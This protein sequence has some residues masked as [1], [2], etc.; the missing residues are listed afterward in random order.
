M[1]QL[2][3]VPG[4]GVIEF[5]DGMDDAA[6]TAAIENE[7]IPQV[8]KENYTGFWGAMKGGGYS[9]L[10]SVNRAGQAVSQMLGYEGGEEYFDKNAQ[11]YQQE[12]ARADPYRDPILEADSFGQGV[13]GVVEGVAGSIP[14]LGASLAAGATGAAIGTAIAPGVGTIIGGLGGVLLASQPSLFGENAQEQI[15]QYGEIRDP[16]LAFGTSWPQALAET[17]IAAATFGVGKIAGGMISRGVKSAFLGTGIEGTTE[18]AQTAA[19]IAQAG[20]D[21]TTPENRMR[22][23]EA[24]IVGGAL[25]GGGVGCGEGVGGGGL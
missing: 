9:S 3:E 8:A 2:I 4:A 7:I 25:G 5:P 12:A 19:T 17:V 22:L 16:W 23:A 13:E 14:Q 21:I 15:E 24:A 10:A 11:Y 18:L 20:G 6:I 1:P